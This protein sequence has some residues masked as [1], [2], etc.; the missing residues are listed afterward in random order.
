MQSRTQGAIVWADAA[1]TLGTGSCGWLG[2]LA[3]EMSVLTGTQSSGPLTVTAEVPN[4]CEIG[5]GSTTSA[6][7]TLTNNGTTTS[8]ATTLRPASGP[9]GITES[10][11]STSVPALAPGAS[12]STTL[13]LTVPSS[14]TDRTALLRINYDG[15]FG[16][17]TVIIP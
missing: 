1:T 6:P 16:R 4:T 14:E 3:H 9:Q 12:W 5:R 17:L 10:Y 15:G 13:S 7:V 8:A 2:D 11:G